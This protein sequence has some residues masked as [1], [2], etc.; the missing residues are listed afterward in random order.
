MCKVK[1]LLLKIQ[2]RPCIIAN[3]NSSA[4]LNEKW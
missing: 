3:T 4:V 2:I 1:I